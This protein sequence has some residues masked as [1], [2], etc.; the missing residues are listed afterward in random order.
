MEATMRISLEKRLQIPFQPG[1]SRSEQ[2]RVLLQQVI[3]FLDPAFADGA[4]VINRSLL[5]QILA[6]SLMD[7]PTGQWYLRQLSIICGGRRLA[8]LP[9]PT[10]EL[11]ERV[12]Q[13]GL[14]PLSEVEFCCLAADPALFISCAEELELEMEYSASWERLSIAAMED[15]L[16]EVEPETVDDR[17]DVGAGEQ[18]PEAVTSGAV[19]PPNQRSAARL[20]P[21]LSLQGQADFDESSEADGNAEGQQDLDEKEDK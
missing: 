8:C 11:I 1:I 6:A 18:R 4:L 2:L 3:Q 17:Q 14:E 16:D 19:P 9:E 21:S 10:V 7:E 12:V 13:F 20:F 15:L 5:Q